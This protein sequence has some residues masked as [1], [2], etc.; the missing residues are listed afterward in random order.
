MSRNRIRWIVVAVVALVLVAVVFPL[1]RRVLLTNR[2][3]GL[4]HVDGSIKDWRFG[5]DG[6]LKEEGIFPISGRWKLASGDEIQIDHGLGNWVTYHYRF[7]GKR[8]VLV[9][10]AMSWGLTPKD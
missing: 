4:W 9:G 2:I 10:D 6:S 1:G 8:L 3:T 5:S 7:D